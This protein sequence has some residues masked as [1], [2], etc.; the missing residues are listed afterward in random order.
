MYKWIRGPIL[1]QRT[2]Y[3]EQADELLSALRADRFAEQRIQEV[4]GDCRGVDVQKEYNSDR[5]NICIFIYIVLYNYIYI[6][7]CIMYIYIYYISTKKHL[8]HK[9]MY[10]YIIYTYARPPKIYLC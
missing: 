2:S 3:Q 7:F 1:L 4:A 8:S 5:Y 6:L 10:I 9:Y